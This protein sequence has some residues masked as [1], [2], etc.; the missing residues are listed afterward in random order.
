MSNHELDNEIPWWIMKAKV[1]YDDM[2]VELWNVVIRVSRVAFIC[3]VGDTNMVRTRYKH[4]SSDNQ[5]R[6]R[7][8]CILKV[9]IAN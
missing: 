6:P 8:V 4:Q 9:E 7:P 3:V 1:M 2:S 5:H